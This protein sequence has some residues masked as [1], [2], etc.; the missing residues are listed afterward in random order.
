MVT[1]VRMLGVGVM[2]FDVRVQIEV[3]LK[4]HVASWV[5]AG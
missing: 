1:D 4:F 5:S 2:R 3:T